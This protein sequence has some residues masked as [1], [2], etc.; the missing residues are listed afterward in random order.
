LG[1]PVKERYVSPY[2]IAIICAGLG[3]KDRALEWLNQAYESRSE[4]MLNLKTDPR[5]NGLRPY[6]RFH[7]LLRRMNFPM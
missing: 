4:G 6:R 5:L 2:D 3:E 1:L 7:S